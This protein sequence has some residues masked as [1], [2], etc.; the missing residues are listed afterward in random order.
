MGLVVAICLFCIF[1]LVLVLKRDIFHPAVIVS[2]IW[3]S[4]LLFYNLIEHPLYPLSD[5]FY[6]AV[7]L[8]VIPFVTV[9]LFIDKVKLVVPTSLLVQTCNEKLLN[10]LFPFFILIVIY[11]IYE[12]IHLSDTLTFDLNIISHLRNA[13]LES[14]DDSMTYPLPYRIAKILSRFAYV[15][16]IC[17]LVCYRKVPKFKVIILGVLICI[18]FLITGAKMGL[19]SFFV[20]L[21]YWC[22]K[23]YHISNRNLFLIMCLSIGIMAFM[24]VMRRDENAREGYDL[25]YTL[26]I[27]AFSAFPAFDSIISGGTIMPE[28][29]LGGYVFSSLSSLFNWFTIFDSNTDPLALYKYVYVPY[30]TNVYTVLNF[31]YLDFG[32]PGVFIFSIIYGIL[33]GYLYK[34]S[35]IGSRIFE[36]IYSMYVFILVFQFFGDF[37]FLQYTALIVSFFACI[38]FI[39]KYKLKW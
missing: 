11:L 16:F 27:Y 3:G 24:Q 7:S 37:F 34:I 26:Q 31:Y 39:P 30:P 12:T 10:K 35:V 23:K 17:Y 15:G 8:W 5:M 36:I 25:L 33:S 9:T 14:M 2:G 4:L 6:F 1:L 29:S 38:L 28:Y 19:L 21:F 18:S 32:L 13:I 22:I 20:L